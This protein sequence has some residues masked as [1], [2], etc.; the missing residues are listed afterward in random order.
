MCLSDGQ[1]TKLFPDSNVHLARR[2]HEEGLVLTN[3]RSYWTEKFR[4]GG[5]LPRKSATRKNCYTNTEILVFMYGGHV[6]V[7]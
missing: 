7:A 1:K 6:L 4:S 3:G 5:L 2:F